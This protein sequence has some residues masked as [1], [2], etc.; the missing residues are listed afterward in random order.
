MSELCTSHCVPCEGG[1]P[2]LTQKEAEHLLREIPTWT[3]G[4]DGLSIS[5]RF[6]FKGF[7]K[8]MEFVNAVAWIV[9]KEMHHPDITM[10]YDYC[11]IQFTTHAINGLSKNDFIC[12]AKVEK[13][14][15]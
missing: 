10:G 2:A 7:R 5:R 4:E 1:V 12:A 9:N 13:L 15:L 14:L 6:P 8:V 3:L 11:L